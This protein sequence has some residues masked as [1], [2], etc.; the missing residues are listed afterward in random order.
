MLAYYPPNPKR[1]GKFHNINVRVTRPGLTV[2]SRRGYANPTG[3]VAGAAEERA[4][5]GV[6]RHAAEPDA[7]QRP[8]DEGVR[9]AVQGHR[10]ERVGAARRRAARARSQHGGQLQDR[11]GVIRGGRQG[12]DEGVEP[13]DACRSTCRPETKTRVEQDGIRLL[14]RMNV[15]AG[16]YQLRVARARRHRRRAGVR[17]VRPRRA[18]LR[19]DAA[20]DERARADVGRRRACCRRPSRTRICARCCRA[21]RRR[22]ATFAQNDQLAFFT[23]V[24]DNDVSPVHTVDI[25]T[26]LT[27][28]EGRVVFKNAEERSTADLAGKPGGF[29]YGTTLSLQDY[30]AR[31]L[32]PK[33][34]GAFAAR[35]RM[36]RRAARCRSPSRRRRASPQDD[37]ILLALIAAFCMTLQPPAAVR[38]IDKGLD[39]QMDD[40]ASGDGAVGGRVGDA[41]AAARAASARARPWTSAR[42]S[43]WRCS[44]AA[45]RPPAFRWR[46]SAPAEDGPALVV[47]YR[48][49][50]P[51]PTRSSRR[52]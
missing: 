43:W 29:G 39:S 4:V 37:D 40:G 21:R 38:S 32:R 44:S 42:K 18:R 15:P 7:G 19:E 2:R 8:G 50:R 25:T 20:R 51:A 5:R 52:C 23:D 33:S 30:R 45:G 10:A 36:P 34:R 11:A 26:T 13:R 35:Q 24:Y 9:R 27:A 22:R 6:A 17:A 49:T 1:D 47:Q 12:Q 41:L 46:S 3:K 31:P 14:S 28:D 48:E 16:R